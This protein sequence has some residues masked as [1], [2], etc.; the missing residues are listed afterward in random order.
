MQHGMF[1]TIFSGLG[2]F[3]RGH[4]T[5]TSRVCM[6]MD[7]SVFNLSGLRVAATFTGPPRGVSSR[8]PRQPDGANLQRP[9]G[10]SFLPG[11]GS[12]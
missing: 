12:S 4:V 7:V 8:I 11:D 10:A 3:H 6:H 5:C 9:M 1:V 2:T